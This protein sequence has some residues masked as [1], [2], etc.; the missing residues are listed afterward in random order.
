[1]TCSLQA[2]YGS[3]SPT[4]AH[5]ETESENDRQ[6]NH[7][8]ETILSIKAMNGQAKYSGDE[9]DSA[10]NGIGLNEG[11]TRCTKS[12]NSDDISVHDGV[13]NDSVLPKDLT[14]DESFLEDD[15]KLSD[16]NRAPS[17]NSNGTAS[18]TSSEGEPTD[19]MEE[20]LLAMDA[21]EKNASVVDTTTNSEEDD[22]VLFL[23]DTEDGD[24]SDFSEK[25]HSAEMLASPKA[26][27]FTIGDKVKDSFKALV[28]KISKDSNSSISKLL[29]K[30]SQSAVLTEMCDSS[31][32]DT[33][34]T[35]YK[36]GNL[37]DNL[38]D[39]TQK[40]G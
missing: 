31:V 25:S 21:E 3:G 18:N 40:A 14:N 28:S 26:H 8:K 29:I 15:D 10:A 33:N 36:E 37:F 13:T 39:L 22:V 16:R 4:R 20:E 35:S 12:P 1:M 24:K 23:S 27:P 9:N 19:R 34:K 5:K 32:S 6:L 30:K 7:I 2:S 11:V 17:A 38:S